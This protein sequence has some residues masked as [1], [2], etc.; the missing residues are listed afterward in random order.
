[1]KT[2]SKCSKNK[3]ATVEYFGRNGKRLNVRCKEC[4][5]VYQKKYRARNKRSLSLS[6]KKRYL[7]NRENKIVA[8]KKWY[9]ENKS[10]K[11][12]YDK[13]RSGRTSE[14]RSA[15]A[16][17]YYQKHKEEI[18]RKTSQYAREKYKTDENFRI[19]LLLRHRLN[20]AFKRFSKNGKVKSSKDYGI[21]WG[22]IIDHIGLCPGN[23]SE[24]HIDHIIPLSAFD[25][26]NLKHIKIAFA[27]EN[28]QWLK[29]E[30][31]LAKSNK[32]D[33][34]D[35]SMLLDKIT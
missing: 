22:K 11:K 20:E 17:I 5:V 29:K 4:D 6:A 24:Y 21:E 15:R 16:K 2:C 10:H 25:F 12:Q 31:N 8:A 18:K 28:H 7:D 9:I 3:P 33:K 19:K 13:E 34:R 23:R 26:D 1:M 35:L 32:Y 30:E 27:P 14:Y